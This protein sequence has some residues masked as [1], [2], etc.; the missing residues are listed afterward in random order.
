MGKMANA[1]I[2]ELNEVGAGDEQIGSGR[3]LWEIG[4]DVRGN[5]KT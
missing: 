3:V 2:W 1:E 5:A 4:Y